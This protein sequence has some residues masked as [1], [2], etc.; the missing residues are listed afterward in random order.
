MIPGSRVARAAPPAGRSAWLSS[1]QGPTSTGQPIRKR[2]CR[3]GL[4]GRAR[5]E[6]KY[7]FTLL[8]VVEWAVHIV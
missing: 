6:I 2:R 4:R 3:H 8:G 5:A 1:W 7:V